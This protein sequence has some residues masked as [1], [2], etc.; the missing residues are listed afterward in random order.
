[1]A[2]KAR[3]IFEETATLTGGTQ[4]AS[5][6]PVTLQMEREGVEEWE[7]ELS[8]ADMLRSLVGVGT[9]SN[10]S[11]GTLNST[12]AKPRI[13]ADTS[14]DGTLTIRVNDV[15]TSGYTFVVM[16][17]PVSFSGPTLFLTLVIAAP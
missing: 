11:V 2:D 6:R 1:M 4:V 8:A 15:G 9:F 3:G 7:L 16:A 14:S 17:R 5:Y 10:I 12:T 13:L